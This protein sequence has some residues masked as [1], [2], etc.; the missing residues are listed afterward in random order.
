[1]M[2]GAEVIPYNI[3]G[4]KGTPECICVEGEIDALSFAEIGRT[5]V[6]SVPTGA[7]TNLSWMDR[8]MESH[9][10]DKKVIYIAVDND[11]KGLELRKALLAR[12]GTE[13]CKI[14]E[15]PQGCKDANEVLQAH[16]P[17]LRAP[18]L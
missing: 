6:I 12:L 3:D 16:H 7:N 1:M 11:N 4:I 10:D 17:A 5:D 2:G 9:F 14:M 15:Y 18:L 8:F 13:R